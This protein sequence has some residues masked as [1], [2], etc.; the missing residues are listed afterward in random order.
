LAA[1]ESGIVRINIA[2]LVATLAQVAIV[3]WPELLNFI[4]QLNRSENLQAREIALYLLSELLEDPSID[5]FLA[6]HM[7]QLMQ[8]F[9]TSLTD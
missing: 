2:S 6:P 5:E 7:Q 1:E 4:D 8:L 3:Y 9:S